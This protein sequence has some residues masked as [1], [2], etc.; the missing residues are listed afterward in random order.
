[1]QSASQALQRC[2]VYQGRVRIFFLFYCVCL[3]TLLFA[4]HFLVPAHAPLERYRFAV[5]QVS[6][7]GDYLAALPKGIE[8]RA[9]VFVPF[10]GGDLIVSAGEQVLIDDHDGKSTKLNRYQSA[11]VADMPTVMVQPAGLR[12]KLERDQNKSGIGPV[13]VGPRDQ[14]QAKA[15]AQ[16]RF[17]ARVQAAMPAALIMAV[18]GVFFLIFFSQTPSRYFYFLLCLL[19][20]VL[21][22]FEPQ[23]QIFGTPL[24]PFVS[25][26]GN[27]Y[28]LAIFVT[29]SLWLGGPKTERRIAA[30]CALVLAALLALLDFA[31]GFDAP[32]TDLS[33]VLAFAVP[34][35]AISIVSGF[36]ALG[37][38]KQGSALLQISIASIAI[39]LSGF[40]LNLI[41]LYIPLGAGAVLPILFL[42]KALGALGITCLAGSALAFEL[43]AYRHT[44]QQSSQLSQITA[45]H[46]V[47]LDEQTRSLK[48]EIEKRAVLEERQRFTRDIHDGIGGQLL[49][50]LLK[51]R[52]GEVDLKAMEIELGNSIND[53]RLVTA[54]LDAADG[55]LQ[56]ALKGFSFRVGDQLKAA[57]MALVWTQ[58]PATDTIKLPPRATLDLLRVM[59]EAVT[60]A[61]HHSQASAVSVDIGVTPDESGLTIDIADNGVGLAHGWQ[62]R[63]GKGIDNM[64]TRA[65]RL[66]GVLAMT[67]GSDGRGTTISLAIPAMA[68]PG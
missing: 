19:F 38:L 14:I 66:G 25:Y 7:T 64:H 40:F 17:I 37:S 55:D 34:A 32:Q 67:A 57:N 48:T 5:K 61:I 62:D 16:F 1:L 4:A 29:V 39:I 6:A 36:R 47:A 27:A 22:E 31:F 58:D 49:H 11:F 23:I 9:A 26:I 15:T 3:A 63:K 10:H 28:L 13:Y 65:E 41:R 30:G 50:M 18:F 33:R 44:R 12:I 45:G 20:N 21:I 54:S 42:T 60:N 52:S 56:D 8:G 46:L 24:R 68:K 59:Q 43:R 35:V 53:L 2:S 51:A